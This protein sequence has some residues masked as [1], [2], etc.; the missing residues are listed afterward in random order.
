MAFIVSR[1]TYNH[2]VAYA[3]KKV[4]VGKKRV[5]DE[6]RVLME[7]FLGRPLTYDECVHHINGDKKDNRFENLEVISRAEH[8]RLHMLGHAVADETKA[9][10]SEKRRQ[11]A[12][13]KLNEEKVREIRAA[14]E[15]YKVL[16]ERYGV[17]LDAI[18]KVRCG[19][20][21]G[22]VV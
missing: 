13:N 15:P 11:S 7:D 6:H 12:A 1:A 9:K 18:K 22:W 5:K 14:T 21:W 4:K 2:F 10:L 16:A 20:K 17:S 19:L 8:S 3:Y